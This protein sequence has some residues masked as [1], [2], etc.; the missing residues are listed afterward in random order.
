MNVLSGSLR[1]EASSALYSELTGVYPSHD[2]DSL[3]YS[4]VHLGVGAEMVTGNARVL[5]V[6][7]VAVDATD[8][9]L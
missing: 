1:S 2:A 9:D 6:N 7:E 3:I 8:H 5:G 4:G